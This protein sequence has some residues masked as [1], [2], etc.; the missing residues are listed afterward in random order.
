MNW[1]S[2]PGNISSW[3]GADKLDLTNHLTVKPT[4]GKNST[5]VGKKKHNSVN[6]PKII[7]IH[8]FFLRVW[9]KHILTCSPQ[10]SDPSYI[11]TK[12]EGA[13]HVKDDDIS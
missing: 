5:S 7:I 10:M 1:T 9:G 2:Q 13:W 4:E 6:I 3:N 8:N 11:N 12:S